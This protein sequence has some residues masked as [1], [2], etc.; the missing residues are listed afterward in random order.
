MTN[1]LRLFDF[2][3]DRDGDFDFWVFD[4]RVFDA[5]RLRL[6]LFDRDLVCRRVVEDERRFVDLD[7]VLFRG[8]ST[9]AVFGLIAD[10]FWVIIGSCIIGS[11]IIDFFLPPIEAACIISASGPKAFSFAKCEIEFSIMIIYL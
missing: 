4:F 1:Y 11:I 5:T 2:D 3:R 10:F 8:V 6:R 9:A 7:A